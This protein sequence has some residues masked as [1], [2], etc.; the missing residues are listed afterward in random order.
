MTHDVYVWQRRWTPALREAL[1]ESRQ[2]VVAW[3]VLGAEIGADGEAIATGVDLDAVRESARPTVV[4]LR[5]DGQITDWNDRRILATALGLV[6]E[7]RGAGVKVSGVEIDY[8]C[9]TRRL[10]AYASFLGRFHDALAPQAPLK[11]T[12]TMLPAWLGDAALADVLRNVDEVVLQTHSV[13]SPER[14][15]FDL[16]LA[17]SWVATLAA[18]KPTSFRVA[19]PTYGHQVS[20][21]AGGLAVAIESEAPRGLGGMRSQELF[22]SP[23]VI[24]RFVGELRQ[25]PPPAFA[26]VAWFRLPTRADRR[27]WS[28]ATWKAVIEGGSMAG[29]AAVR[30]VATDTP[31]TF[32]LVAVN[33]TAIDRELPRAFTVVNGDDCEEADALSHYRL[34]PRQRGFRFSLAEPALLASNERRLIGWVRC[35]QE[36]MKIDA[37]PE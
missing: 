26:G 25:D 22:A 29:T 6:E 1:W 31:G 12:I 4:V 27:A 5:I 24:S 20:F 10:P 13:L 18:L 14:G 28:L 21:D 17:R 15:L 11:L 16:A 36:V 9:A 37:R 3:R 30:A 23:D 33:Q 8:D 32:D 2:L 34:D 7:F 35:P 19:L